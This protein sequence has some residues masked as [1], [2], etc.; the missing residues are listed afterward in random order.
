ME[1]FVQPDMIAGFEISEEDFIR[2]DGYDDCIIGVVERFGQVP[3]ICYDKTKVL[4][5]LEKE[6]EMTP[7]EALE[8]WEYNQLGS[9]VGAATPCFI[10]LEK[11][12]DNV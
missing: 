8:Y 11:G 1:S 7:E 6:D 2:M 3:I 9:Y 10:T 5:K 4:A 12:Q